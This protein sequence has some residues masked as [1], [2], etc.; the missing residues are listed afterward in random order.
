MTARSKEFAIRLARGGCALAVV[1]AA[2]AGLAQ[3]GPGYL[4]VPT[5]HPFKVLEERVSA[6]VAASGMNLVTRASASDGARARGFTIRGDAVLGIF[7]NDFA[8]RMLEANVDAGIEAPIRLHLVEEGDG[9]TT[10]RYHAPSAVFGKYDGDGIKVL[11]RELDP[12][13]AAIV[14]EAAGR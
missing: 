1:V 4:V 3:T 9:T 5:P 12:V 6:A 11:G 14:R 2:S 10:I 7:R 8:V 13:F